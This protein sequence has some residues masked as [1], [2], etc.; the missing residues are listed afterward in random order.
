MRLAQAS[1]WHYCLPGVQTL[2][3]KTFEAPSRPIDNLNS[4]F[5]GKTGK[6]ARE[7]FTENLALV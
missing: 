3:Y 6:F 1:G 2:G 5:L 7:I 4:S